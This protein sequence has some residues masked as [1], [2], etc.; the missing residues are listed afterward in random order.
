MM[1]EEF[2][3]EAIVIESENGIADVALLRTDNCEECS[4]KIFCKPKADNTKILRVSDPYGVQPGDEVKI[5]VAGGIVLKYSFIVYGIPLILLIA[6][7]LGGFEFFHNTTS[8]ELFSFLFGVS[9]TGI[10]FLGAYF[11]LKN[12]NSDNFMPKITFVRKK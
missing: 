11:V 2:N 3:E 6:G 1:H 10:Y 9:L 4:A 7:I 5:A 8:P 12:N